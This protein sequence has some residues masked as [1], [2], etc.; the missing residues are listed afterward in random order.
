MKIRNLKVL[1]LTIIFL[2]IGITVSKGSY[3]ASNPTVNSGEDITITVTSTEALE[4]YNLDLTNSAGLTFV[5]C[6]KSES[7]AIID[8]TGSSIGYIN[9]SGSTKTLGTYKFKA[10]TVT[11]KR[12]YTIEFLVDQATPV[13]STV[14]VNPKQETPPTNTGNNGSSTNGGD[15]ST[16]KPQK[17]TVTSC[18]INGIKVNE[19]INIKN[20]NSVS[21]LV[22]TSTGEGFKIYNNL[23]KKTTT[24]KSGVNTNVAIAEG[25]NVLTITLDSGYSTTRNINSTKETVVEPN[26]IE[27][28]P[29]EEIKVLLK[30]LAIKGVISEEEEKID[31]ALTPEFSSEVY[32]YTLTIPPEQ[33]DITKLDVEAIGAQEDFTIEI[34]GNEELVD[35]ENTVTIL[36]KSKDGEKTATYQILVVKQP[37]EVEAVAV[38]A[39]VETTQIPQEVEQELSIPKILI[40]VFTSIIAIAGIVFGVIEYR[41]S[42]NK[43]GEFSSIP[44]A[45]IGF[46]SENDENDKEDIL[47]EFKEDN[48]KNE[49]IESISKNDTEE[50]F[51]VLGEEEKK[52]KKRG[53][54]F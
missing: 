52:P 31:L 19:Y 8:I 53:K 27:E 23:T 12:T 48:E 7:G 50:E 18:K 30:S 47:G 32:E 2:A 17:G 3:S 49:E 41:Y 45:N 6:S 16:P 44:Y 34:T 33:N 15:T 54:H 5:S 13:K 4:A 51:E 39:P 38:A 14:T 37:K 1:L 40:A 25:T 20:Q 42:K 26:V 24:G 29:E 22:N 43:N 11:E 35:G 21:V 9:A 28:E 36:V 46:D 10:P